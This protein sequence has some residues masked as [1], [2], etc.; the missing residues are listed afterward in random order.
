MKAATTVLSTI[1]ALSAVMLTSSIPADAALNCNNPRRVSTATAKSK[2]P[3]KMDG[4]WHARLLCFNDLDA[5]GK[6]SYGFRYVK[7]ANT[8]YSCNAET[9]KKWWCVCAGDPCVSTYSQIYTPGETKNLHLPSRPPS[10]RISSPG[11]RRR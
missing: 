9:A 7:M 3:Y 2:Q 8:S 1:A 5:K 10:G 6:A 4:K 11:S